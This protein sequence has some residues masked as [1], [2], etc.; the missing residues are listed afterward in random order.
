LK[1]FI[2]LKKLLFKPGQPTVSL[3]YLCHAALRQHL[4]AMHFRGYSAAYASASSPT[5]VLLHYK[6]SR[7]SP[8]FIFLRSGRSFTTIFFLPLEA[9]ASPPPLHFLPIFFTDVMLT[10][11][12]HIATTAD[13]QSAASPPSPPPSIAS[14]STYREHPSCQMAP[15]WAARAPGV[16]AVGGLATDSTG[17][18]RPLPWSSPQSRAWCAWA[19]GP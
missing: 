17:T 14:P 2:N 8:F 16:I 3:P 1:I 4:I 13:G 9:L 12:P 10:P 18:A 19:V 7:L 5:T 11:H 15:G 6:V